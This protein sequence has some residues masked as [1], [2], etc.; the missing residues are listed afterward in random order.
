MNISDIRNKDFS[1]ALRGYNRKE[2]KEFLNE[3]ASAIDGLSQENKNLLNQ[4]TEL[5]EKVNSYQLREKKIEEL[6]TSTQKKT[7][8]LLEESKKKANF[9]I[10][11]AQIKARKI[12]EEENRKIEK[13][14][15]EVKRLSTQR[16]LLLNKI[17]AFIQS[18]QQ[19]IEFYEEDKEDYSF[20]SPLPSST[21]T[22]IKKI[23][24]EE[25]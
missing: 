2:V 1:V 14:K 18:Q 10:K 6:I 25:E 23:I 7:K 19:L 22:P 21:S 16:K 12:Q 17:K 3:L 24:I 11:E 20:H 9:I 13:L 5:K 15:T 4:I 8:M